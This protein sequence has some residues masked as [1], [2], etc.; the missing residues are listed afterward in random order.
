MQKRAEPDRI[1]YRIDDAALA[2]GLS[3]SKL[4][5]LIKSGE[6]RSF[7]AAGRR[8]ILRAELEAYLLRQAAA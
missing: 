6:L 7:L 3:R 5:Q 1:A 4:Y 2:S 8:L